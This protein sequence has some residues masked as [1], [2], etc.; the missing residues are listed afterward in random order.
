[1]NILILGGGGRE[2]AF[3]WKLAQSP[4]C[5]QLY[6]APGNAGTAEVGTNVDIS[7]T[8]FEAIHTFVKEHGVDFI[9]A[10]PEAPL[11]AGVS[12]YF[13]ERGIPVVGPV[14]A[15]AELEGSK[16]FSK[17]FMQTYNIP[18]AGYRSFNQDQVEEAME[19]LAGHSLPIVVKASGLAAGKGVLICETHEH[20]QEVTKDMLSGEAF[21]EA[22]QTVVIEEFLQGIEISIF[23]LT[24]GVNYKLLPS[25]KDYKRIGEDDTGLN[26][27]GMGAVSPVPFADDAFV[28]QVED[29]IVKPTMDGLNAEGITYK[30]FIFIGLMVV[31]GTP[32]VLEYNVRMGDP[33]TEVVMPR[34]EADLVDL[35]QGVIEGNLDEKAFSIDPRTCTTVM[36]VSGG[37]PGSY[38]KGKVMTGWDQTEGSIL[39]HAGTKQ[40]GEDIVTNGGRVLAIS[41]FGQDIASAVAQSLKNAEQIQFE[42]KYFRTDIGKDLQR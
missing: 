8:D 3:A 31:E 16:D 25:A 14:K 37:Y 39:F 32:Y 26:T 36:M 19:Y 17:Q 34:L 1:M 10:G 23:V 35:F 15:G 13:A 40:A 33:E 5:D 7:A 4:Q 22:G 29:T 6:I 21:G 11:V 20:A 42:G 12:D 27:G 9:V 2:H 41:S 30:G 28:K 38:E 18:T 24:D